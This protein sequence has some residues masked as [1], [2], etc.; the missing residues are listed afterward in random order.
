ME[1]PVSSARAFI[2]HGFPRTWIA[3]PP[4]GGRAIPSNCGF[5][6]SCIDIFL[7]FYTVMSTKRMLNILSCFRQSFFCF[8]R[9]PEALSGTTNVLHPACS[10]LPRWSRWVAASPI[11]HW[12]SRVPELFA[13]RRIP[14]KRPVPP[15]R[16]SILLR[17]FPE[18]DRV[19]VERALFQRRLDF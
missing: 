14:G 7:S 17:S 8:S 13:D 18:K 15:F 12:S 2:I 6:S 5:F 4:S 3:F 10:S 16:Q 11:L 1:P 9:Y 19:P